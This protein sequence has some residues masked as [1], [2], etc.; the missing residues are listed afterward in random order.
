MI[1]IRRVD[2]EVR[3]CREIW[4]ITGAEEFVLLDFPGLGA[5]NSGARDT[6]LS[7]RELAQVQTILVLLNGKSPGSDRANKIFSMMQ[8]QRPGQDLKDL[9]L[10][11]VGPF[12]QL[13]LD[14]EGGEKILDFLIEDHPNG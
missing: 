1:F 3:I 14:S 8:Q 5:A 11:G 6:F 12:D 4:D 7:L 2:I 10:V 13:P 9:I